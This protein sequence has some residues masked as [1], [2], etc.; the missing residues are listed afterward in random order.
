VARRRSWTD[1]DLI[2]ALD[3]ARSWSEVKRRLGLRG[4]GRADRLRRR[5]EE[6]HLDTSS[7]P[8]PDETWRSWTDDD[9]RQAVSEASNL[10][11]V[12]GQLGLSVGGQA[13][14]RMQEHIL[15]LELDTSHWDRHGVRP[16]G[17]RRSP[18]VIDDQQL[19]DVLPKVTTRA[20]LARRLGLE[21]TSGTVQRRLRER[22]DQLGLP[23]DHLRGQGWAKGRPRSSRRRPLDEILVAGS[24]HRG[25]WLRDRL[26]Q[27]GVL[28]PRCAMC[29]I[30]RWEGQRAPLQLDHVDGD[31]TNNRL[32]NLRLLCPNCHALTPTYC[33]RNIGKR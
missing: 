8:G 25:S 20:E 23:T 4:G 6:L 22:I 28:R 15:R 31:P 21:P 9:L 11:Q 14:R 10:A 26:L 19:R 16:G 5:C 17:P 33:G 27:E 1:E 13:W 3:G 12:F 32:E 29:G 24:T 18:V 7:L 30:E 2:D